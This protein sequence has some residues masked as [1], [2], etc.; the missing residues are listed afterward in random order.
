MSEAVVR[1]VIGKAV[2]DLEYREPL[3]N[4][5]GKV[6]EGLNLTTDEISGL[7]AIEKSAF[8]VEGSELEARV[9][10]AGVSRTHGV[11]NTHDH[12]GCV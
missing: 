2:I 1:E 8:D 5:P 9:S 10:R 4:D 6:L 3:F 7:K 12:A 11:A